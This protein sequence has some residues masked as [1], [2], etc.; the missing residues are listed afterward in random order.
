MINYIVTGSFDDQLIIP[1]FLSETSL[2]ALSKNFMGIELDWR[3]TLGVC[4][5][6]SGKIGS[7][8]CYLGRRPLHKIETF[9]DIF[10]EY[11]R[12]QFHQFI[13]VALSRVILIC[14]LILYVCVDHGTYYKLYFK[15]FKNNNT[16]HFSYTN[17]SL[18]T[19]I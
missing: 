18:N 10:Y 3:V 2:G 5:A 12:K 4:N 11:D 6:R 17:C 13:Y 7:S 1:D 15:K 19:N 9:N 16:A 8:H 14:Y